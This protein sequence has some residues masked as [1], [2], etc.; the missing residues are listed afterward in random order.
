MKYSVNLPFWLILVINSLSFNSYT[1]NFFELQQR[2][3]HFWGPFHYAY[4]L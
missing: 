2:L 1:V 3:A 4:S